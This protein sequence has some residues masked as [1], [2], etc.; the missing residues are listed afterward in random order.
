M[1]LRVGSASGAGP[2]AAPVVGG[3]L[4]TI[5]SMR[6]ALFLGG[7]QGAAVSRDGGRK[8]RSLPSLEGADVMGWATPPGAV[9]V[10]GHPGLYRSSDGGTSFTKVTGRADVP[11]AHALGGAGSTV[12]LASPEAGLMVS[13]DAGRTWQTRSPS[14]GRSFMGTILVDPRDPDRLVAPDMSGG[15]SAS[16]DGGRSFSPLG[17]PMGAMAVAWNP[18]NTRE[19]VAVGMSGASR[20]TDSGR[21]WQDITV[22][23]AT[24]AITFDRTGRT[25]YAGAL[26]G[27]QGYAYRSTDGGRSWRPTA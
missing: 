10:G 4:H 15:I 11:D 6:G 18:A 27:Q 21:T 17:G 5:T 22:P 20:S 7:H 13:T 23:P 14:A 3:D 8:W 26:Q 1:I 16:T 2:A 24:S 12:Y 25:L 19:L 9:L